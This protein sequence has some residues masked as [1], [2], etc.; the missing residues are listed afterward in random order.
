MAQKPNGELTSA[1]ELLREQS[2]HYEK[3]RFS[4]RLVKRLVG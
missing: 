3:P 4:W 1:A 2:G